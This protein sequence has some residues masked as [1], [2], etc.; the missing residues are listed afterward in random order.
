MACGAGMAESTGSKMVRGGT[1]RVPDTFADRHNADCG[2]RAATSTA[3]RL[4]AADD[5]GLLHLAQHIM[6]D[7]GKL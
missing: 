7:K 5:F 2:W 6:D 3:T 4:L 1:V